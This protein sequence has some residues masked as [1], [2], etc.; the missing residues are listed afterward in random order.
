VSIKLDKVTEL[1][2]HR[3]AYWY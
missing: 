1:A 2:S 3:H